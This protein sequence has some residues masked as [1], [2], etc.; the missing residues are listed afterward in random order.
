MAE[1]KR[2]IYCAQPKSSDEFSKEHIIPQ[3]MGGSSDCAAAVT[4]DACQKCNSLFGRFVDGPVAR[5]YFLR[6]IEQGAWAACFDFNENAGNIYP[7]TYFGKSREIQFGDDEEV[8]VWLCPDGGTAWHVHAQQPEDFNVLAGGDP[9]LRRKDE[10]GRVYSFLASEH[11][12]WALS[13]LKSVQAH[14]TEEP[15]FLGTDSDMEVQ[16]D[17]ARQRG[18]FCQ[19]DSAALGERNRIRA[20]LDQPRLLN[21]SIK[22]DMLFD[23]RFL[24]KLAIA[25]GFK[26]LGDDFGNL[27]YTEMLRN[28]LWTR[29]TNLDTI[30]HQLKMKPYFA[31]LQDYSFKNMRFPHGFVFLVKAF[32][33]GLILGIIFPSGHY[34]QVSITDSTIDSGAEALVRNVEDYVLVSIAQ[35]KKTLGPIQLP[36]FI[37]WKLG[38][39]KIAELDDIVRRLTDR[40]TMPK[41]R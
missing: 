10:S 18:K 16:L 39:Y 2:C 6:S 3:F 24:A 33:E 4:N 23:V 38:S 32:K 7:L 8:E 20:L 5:G 30:Q 14:F 35:L 11:P 9:V 37:A 15:I 26:I 28:L 25:F 21:H 29:R 27:R 40:T 31:G 22:M 41:L 17:R 34:A 12:Y 19:K 36:R 13:N 1:T